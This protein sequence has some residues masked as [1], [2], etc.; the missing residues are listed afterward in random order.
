M[1]L[2]ICPEGFFRFGQP[3]GLDRAAIAFVFFL[4]I[5]HKEER[6]LSAREPEGGQ[7]GLC[8]RR[9]SSPKRAPLERSRE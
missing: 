3:Q 4:R 7:R 5:Q 6:L 9:R 1:E 2:D 8:G